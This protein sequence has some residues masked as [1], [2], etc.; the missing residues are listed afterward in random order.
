MPT[1][2]VGADFVAAPAIPSA[3]DSETTTLA[4]LLPNTSASTDQALSG[5]DAIATVQQVTEATENLNAEV[6]TARLEQSISLDTASAPSEPAIRRNAVA[7]PRDPITEGGYRYGDKT[8]L[9]TSTTQTWQA[10]QSEAQRLGGNLVTINDAAEED[11][12]QL[13]FGSQQGFWIGISDAAQEG[14][15]TWASGEAVDYTNW[16]PG[17]P[18]DLQGNQD[19]GWMNFGASQQWDDNFGNALMQGIIEI[20]AAQREDPIPEISTPF[21]A[22]PG[23]LRLTSNNVRVSEDNAAAQV[24]VVRENGSDARITINYRTIAGSATADQDYRPQQG[25]LT[26]A[27]GETQKT[28]E[29]PLLSDTRVEGEEQFAIALEAPTGGATLLAPRT[30]QI[31]LLDNDSPI[32]YEFRGNT[33]QLSTGEKSWGEVQAEALSK[34]GNLVTINSAEED[35]WLRQ[36]FGTTEGFWTGLNDQT[37]EGNFEWASGQ[38][39]AYT[40][41]AP[42]QP[43]NAYGIQDY[44]QINYG[45]NSQSGNGQNNQS[46]HWNDIGGQ[47]QLRGIIEIGGNN[48]PPQPLTTTPAAT[49]TAQTLVDG[50]NLP[51]A[52]DWL[53]N[54]N[55]LIAE[56]GG[57]VQIVENGRKLDTPFID[58]SDRVNELRG[59]LGIAVH[60]DFSNNPYV[61]LAYA[62]DPPDTFAFT[63]NAGPDGAGNRASRLTRVTADAR[64]NY[65]TAVPDSEVVLLGKNSTWENFN[66]FVNSTT[67]L[68]EAPAGILPD[69]SNLQDFLAADSESHTIG[70]I[71]FGTDGALYV[72]NGDGTSYNQLDERTLRVQDIDNLSGKILRIDPITGEGLTDNPFYNGNRNAN[73]SKVYQYGLRNPFRFAVDSQ[74]NQPVIGDVGWTNWEEINIAGP[75]AN[76]GWP[77]YEGGN[78][79]SLRTTEYQDLPAAQDFYRRSPNGNPNVTSAFLGLNHADDN[80][81]AVIM[82]D[83]YRA[84]AYPEQ[85][86]G[87]IFYNHL[88]QGTVRNISRDSSGN[89]TNVETFATGATLVVQIKT[90]PNGELHF[91]DLD[92]GAVGKW[93]F[94]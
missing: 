19:Y 80:I 42:G 66:P 46:G 41:W 77:Y 6:T 55:L 70:D 26:F 2:A 71:R 48:T 33:Y 22:D 81:D 52:I 37:R 65:R 20:P 92:D 44:V 67:D 4:T 11:W 7:S 83:V 82:G 69:G 1:D 74:T 93:T 57:T 9:L 40:N 89:I 73:R 87:D 75:G 39:I 91:V 49:P 3:T 63:G 94:E 62:Y 76:F 43:N 47:T 60:P 88:G 10:A 68:D 34:G 56:K 35:A 31:T 59:L 45:S 86:K 17:E 32:L 21:P 5:A 25:T 28:I 38:A 8:Y 51:T 12:L 54:N 53:P 18:S 14:T 24:T 84:D 23:T 78:G 72:S 36:T 58:L 16:A 61:Y 27:A 64:T 13:V 79:S 85:Y 30:A 29:I 50:L 90:G 15:F